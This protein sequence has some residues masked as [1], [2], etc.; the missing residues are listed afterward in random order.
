MGTK[1]VHNQKVIEVNKVCN[2]YLIVLCGKCHRKMHN[3]NDDIE[4]T[5]QND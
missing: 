2:R 3:L 1:I 5:Q 4:E